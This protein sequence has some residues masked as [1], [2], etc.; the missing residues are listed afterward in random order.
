MT[1]PVQNH[2]S[3]VRA[4][5]I[6]VRAKLELFR[7]YLFTEYEWSKVRFHMCVLLSKLQHWSIVKDICR[8]FKMSYFAIFGIIFNPDEPP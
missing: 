7:D 3:Q 8:N 1:I 2:K 6:L 5:R 4:P